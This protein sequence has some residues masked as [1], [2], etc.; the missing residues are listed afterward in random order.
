MA[1]W[2]MHV[3]ASVKSTDP[4]DSRIIRIRHSYSCGGGSVPNIWV[5]PGIGLSAM[6]GNDGL[7]ELVFNDGSKGIRIH[8]SLV[9][10][11]TRCDGFEFSVAF[12]TTNGLATMYDAFRNLAER[13]VRGRILTTDYLGFNDPDALEWLLEHTDHE[14][15]VCEERFH[16]KGFVFH[17][18]GKTSAFIG[19]HN[20]TA[21]ALCVNLE[22]GLK[23]ESDTE[24]RLS[25]SL[26]SEFS[27][28]WD[29]SVPLTAE[30]ISE[31]RERRIA[32]TP[33]APATKESG[34]RRITP[35]AMQTEALESLNR[36][37]EDGKTKA[38]LI[39]ATGTGKTYLS[40]FDVRNC[41][42]KRFL[43]MVHSENILR[44]SRDSY[45]AVLGDAYTYGFFTGG[46]KNPDATAV[47]TTVQTMT[48]HLGEFDPDAF[49][50]IVC[51]EAHHSTAAMYRAVID[52]FRP[53]FMLG[54][55][56]TPERMD[57]GDV[58]ALFDYNVAYEI[59]LGKALEMRILCPFHY[60][61]VTEI[62]VDGRIIDDDSDFGDLTCDE[63]V[64]NIV[65]K[66]EYYKPHG[67][68]TKGLIFC[69]S[70]DEAE[71]ISEKMNGLGYRTVALS[72]KDPVPA[73]ERAM[74]M[75]RTDSGPMLDYVLVR[76][77]FNEGVDIPEVNQ[78]IMLRPTESATIFIQQLGRGL[79]LTSD[80]EKSLVVVDFIGNYRNNFMIPMAISGDRSHDKDSLRR[81]MMG[82]SLPGSS[83]I[84]FEKIAR[85]RILENIDVSRLSQLKL[86]K[87]EYNL[88]KARLGRS[89]TLCDLLDGGSLDPTVLLSYDNGTNLN[90]FRSKIG[91]GSAVSMD[92][93]DS[94]LLT[95]VSGFADGKRKHELVLIRD[96]MEQGRVDLGRYPWDEKP[97]Y[98][99]AAS[100]L[101]GSYQTRLTLGKHP[102]WIAVERDGDVLTMSPGL[103]RLM[104]VEE[105]RKLAEDAVACGLRIN[106]ERYHDTDDLGFQR[107]SK[108]TR[109]DVCRI[110]NWEKDCSST[111]YGYMIRGNT[112]PIFVTY[113]KSEDIS[114]STMYAEGF[115]NGT[116]FNWMSRSN[117]TMESDEVRRILG[118]G[119][120]LLF[121][122]K[123]SDSEGSDFY[124]MGR[125]SPI[126]GGSEETEI[127]GKPVVEIPLSL[128]NPVPEELYRYLTAEAAD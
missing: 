99:S 83:T 81:F 27:R 72:A 26:A 67:T 47:F 52:R 10:E 15:R 109:A 84:G 18:R 57:Q 74:S 100:V 108:Y 61:G 6:V 87:N 40:A 119:L 22:W 9:N 62:S 88:M 73:R 58:F 117:R 69:R 33:R 98:E 37:R 106:S 91:D 16:T 21:D 96:V 80:P 127:D 71:S 29:M 75:L 13:G 94:E 64:R 5:S 111:M 1:E 8:M 116:T 11:M 39:S 77:V 45:E 70:V 46:E 124:Y 93:D 19:S 31:Y 107:Y 30:W 76:D 12:I 126:P 55:T 17:R 66:A 86:I 122:V 85:E 105:T 65:E 114:R 23:V 51:D 90:E 25:E 89:P 103:L 63:R 82:D 78:I 44:K 41:A 49:D 118:G 97:S 42:P 120:D 95:F 60:Y 54:M 115:E 113:H 2:N 48:R 125:V 14:I 38:L 4:Y 24:G 104:S 43:F 36:L 121:F 50:Y 102:G 56:A 68:R 79:R 3:R 92:R 7:P 123:K 59:R 112:C 53:R 34:K 101:D 32:P 128:A 28:M 20:L 35:N 110:L